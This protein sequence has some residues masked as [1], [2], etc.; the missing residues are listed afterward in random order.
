M[1][2]HL[3][4]HSIF[5]HLILVLFLVDG[6][7]LFLE[8]AHIT[9]KRFELMERELLVLYPKITRPIQKIC[10]TISIFMVVGISH[11]RWAAVSEPVLHKMK[12]RSTRFRRLSL[13]TY[14]MIIFI[15][16]IVYNVP[17][18]LELDLCWEKC[19]P[20]SNY[21]ALYNRYR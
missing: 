7:Y 5:N 16:S 2:K 3:T 21:S 14:I 8:M 6:L 11:E 20:N 12:M 18:F 10:L 9:R 13:S 4:R 19:F 15:G 17:R 1:S